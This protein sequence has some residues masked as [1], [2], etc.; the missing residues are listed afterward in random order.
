MIPFHY[1]NRW[2][3]KEVKSLWYEEEE[4]EI[5][6]LIL[7]RPTELPSVFLE[8]AAHAICRIRDLEAKLYEEK[9]RDAMVVFKDLKGCCSEEDRKVFLLVPKDRTPDNGFK[10]QTE[11]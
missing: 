4:E 10:L 9:V 3:K 7:S 5:F 11:I 2:G 8:V 1:Q 6:G